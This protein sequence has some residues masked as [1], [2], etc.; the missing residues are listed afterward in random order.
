MRVSLQ[1]DSA[2]D[3]NLTSPHPSLQRQCALVPTQKDYYL[4]TCPLHVQVVETPTITLLA[5]ASLG[6]PFNASPTRLG[7]LLNALHIVRHSCAMSLQFCCHSWQGQ[8]LLETLLLPFCLQQR[9]HKFG[10]HLVF[11]SPMLHWT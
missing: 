4:S 7:N 8:I 10:L 2:S 9:D 5:G 3:T 11:S 1:V 6:P